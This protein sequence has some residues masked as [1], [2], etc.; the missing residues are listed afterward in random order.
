MDKLSNV[1]N[2]PVVFF[3]ERVPSQNLLY[4]VLGVPLVVI[5]A[6]TPLPFSISWRY[7]A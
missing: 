7:V 1:E 6:G 5:F 4:R 3:Y 2:G